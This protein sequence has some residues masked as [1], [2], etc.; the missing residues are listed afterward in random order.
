LIDFFFKWYWT[1]YSKTFIFRRIKF[2]AHRQFSDEDFD[3]TLDA[4][5]LCPSSTIYVHID[6]VNIKINNFLLFWCWI[7]ERIVQHLNI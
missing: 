1:L 5:N 7:A 3:Q 2:I 6:K 4:L